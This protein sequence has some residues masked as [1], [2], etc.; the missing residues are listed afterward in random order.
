MRTNISNNIIPN[1]YF[2]I[3]KKPIYIDFTT[4]VILKK[5]GSNCKNLELISNT[6]TNNTLLNIE[7]VDS[8]HLHQPILFDTKY[9]LQ[10][11]ITPTNYFNT[12]FWKTKNNNF[13][14]DNINDIYVEYPVKINSPNA[15]I[16]NKN[17]YVLNFTILTNI[18][19]CSLCFSTQPHNGNK[20]SFPHH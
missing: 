14:S 5:Y 9:T 16:I 18:L 12:G 15:I 3:G 20:H 4:G 13:T 1:N 7:L 2:I 17:I 8:T 11:R 19:S 6:F 10:H